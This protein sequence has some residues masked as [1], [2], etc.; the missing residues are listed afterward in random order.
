MKS[1]P[2]RILAGITLA[3][4]AVAAWA[5]A[6]P[7]KMSPMP[8]SVVSAPA[9]VSMEFSEELDPKFSKIV[10]DDAAGA[11]VSQTASQVDPADAKH[12]TLALPTLKPAV[13]TVNWTSV[14]KDG[15]K[16]TNSYKFTVK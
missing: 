11:A 12:M 5:H 14:A 4:A 15:H 16:L 7:V 2:T 10:V 9:M 13:Y 3:T 1:W 8:D 6:H